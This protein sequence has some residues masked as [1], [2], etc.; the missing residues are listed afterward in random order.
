MAWTALPPE[1]QAMVLSRVTNRARIGSL[2]TVCREWQVAIERKTFRSLKVA[3]T[4]LESFA[5]ILNNRQPRRQS[6][7][8]VLHFHIVL[9]ECEWP[10]SRARLIEQSERNQVA[11]A[12]A[13]SKLFGILHTWDAS[14]VTQG[15]AHGMKL[16]LDITF[17]SDP[18]E[19]D[20]SDDSD[21]LKRRVRSSPLSFPSDPGRPC[22]LKAV[23]VVTKFST[24]RDLCLDLH[25]RTL[26]TILGS[27]TNLKHLGLRSAAWLLSTSGD[28][29]K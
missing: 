24:D 27:C 7:I 8:K 5:Q 18:D 10:G 16:E 22:I 1:L 9:P 21:Y 17:P 23:P 29:G 15:I 20:D 6:S 11:F 13:I 26:A 3:A 2:A 25:H 19:S 28:V 12:D 14:A 4:E